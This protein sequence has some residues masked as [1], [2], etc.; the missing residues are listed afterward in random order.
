M[1]DVACFALRYKNDACRLSQKT[2]LADATFGMASLSFL[3][4]IALERLYAV[5]CPLRH[6][7]TTTKNYYYVIGATWTV[8]A[9]LITLTY[10]IFSYFSVNDVLQP[11]VLSTYMATCLV[12]ITAAYLTIFIYSRRRVPRV[13]L[14][15]EQNHNKLAKTL[16]I[17]TLLSVITWTPFGIANILR[18]TTGNVEGEVYLSGQFCRLA[19]SYVNPIVY[20]LRMPEFRER[21]INL[22]AFKRR[23]KNALGLQSQLTRA[24]AMDPDCP[25]LLSFTRLDAIQEH[26]PTRIL[27]SKI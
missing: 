18:F 21:L 20:C 13:E 23:S 27:E 11:I 4:V 2:N 26:E 7:T 24:E 12:I 3:L 15:R 1:E 25:V 14:N 5:T 17:V 16:F 19:N 22:F 8:S 10:P 6:R 9:V